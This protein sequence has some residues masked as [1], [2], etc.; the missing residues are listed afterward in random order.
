MGQGMKC[1]KAQNIS[2]QSFKNRASRK[3]ISKQSQ[4]DWC[5]IIF[6]LMLIKNNMNKISEKAFAMLCYLVLMDHHGHGYI[7][8]HPSYIEEKL[9]ILNLGIEAWELLDYPNQRKVLQYLGHWKFQVPEEI[10]KQEAVRKKYHGE[11]I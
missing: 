1:L 4:R 2:R 8:A 7:D 9:Y 6:L 3:I 5:G 10:K 11:N